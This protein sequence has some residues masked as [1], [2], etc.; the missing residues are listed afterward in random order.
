MKPDVVAFC[1]GHSRVLENLRLA[2]AHGAGSAVVY[3]GG[4]GEQGE[5]GRRLQADIVGLCR[6]AGIALCGPNCMG[7][8][9]P[10]NGSTTYMQEIRETKGLAGN[11]GLISQ[12]GSI[13]IGMLSDIRRFGY[14]H[15]VS[16]GNEAVVAMVDY[17]EYL[18]DDEDTKVIAL[19][20][21]TAR[22]PDR[23]GADRKSVV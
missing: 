3:G 23:F 19:F 12:S 6:E 4:F 1:V 13:C 21:E 11:V 16:S 15:I 14:S 2:A 10:G 20:V 5:E 8:L 22:D 7:I 17:L 9:S 18:M